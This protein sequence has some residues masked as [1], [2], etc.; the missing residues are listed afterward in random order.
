MISL[1]KSAKNG[2]LPLMAAIL[3][4][5]CLGV[6]YIWSVFQSGVANALFEGNNASASLTYSLLLAIL[7]V[8]SVI[9]GILTKKIPLKFVV[10]IGGF[11]LSAGFFLASYTTPENPW[12]IW[13]TYGVMG[14]IGMGFS[15]STT[16]ACAQKWFP[17]KKGMV[18]GLIVASLG[19]GGLIFTPIVETIIASNGGKG[20]GEFVAFRI[21]S[22]V[23][24]VVCTIGSL[25]LNMPKE[26]TAMQNNT[27]ITTNLTPLQVIKKPVFYLL[28]ASL[29]LSCMSGLMMIGFAKPIAEGRGLTETATV[30]VLMISLF[31][32]FGRFFWG[33]MS[34]KLGRTKI[35][36]I[37]MIATCV[38]SLLVNFATGNWI[39][40]LIASIGFFYGGLLSTYPALTAE[41]FGGKNVAT[42]YGMVLIGFGVAAVAS[43][44]IAGYFKDLAKDDI[45]Q[46]FPAFAIAAVCSLTACVL[47]VF[48]HKKASD[49]K[50]INLEEKILA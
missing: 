29:M 25:F 43:S 37:L 28:T 9:G 15:Y 34:D 22:V 35:L 10:M 26:E 3:I 50:K 47:V 46:M 33:L 1:E 4:Q 11:I 18:T 42:I 49:S 7:T 20:E 17:D 8:G 14:G 38:S 5:L 45:S 13:L 32:A 19:L 30:G 41:L 6:A 36:F 31:N 44:Y 24:L 12:R 23:F 2:F 27:A 40:V 48:I 21:I 39:F 16:I